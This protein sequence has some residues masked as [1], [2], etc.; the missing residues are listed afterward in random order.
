M[1]SHSFKNVHM[2]T[3]FPHFSRN[4][5]EIYLYMSLK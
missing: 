1:D 3:K 4:D 2:K 5:I